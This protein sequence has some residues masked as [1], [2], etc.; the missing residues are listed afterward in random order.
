MIL[1][2]RVFVFCL[3][4]VLILNSHVLSLFDGYGYPI[5]VSFLSFS[6]VYS[7]YVNK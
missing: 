7:I 5:S 4:Y 2:I 1:L 6:I 3:F